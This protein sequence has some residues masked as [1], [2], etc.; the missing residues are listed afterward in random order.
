[1]G[2]GAGGLGKRVLGGGVMALEGGG[3]LGGAFLGGQ[4]YCC[5]RG[6]FVGA[7]RGLCS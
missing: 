1:M 7:G 2:L 4:R 3:G 6:A 5:G